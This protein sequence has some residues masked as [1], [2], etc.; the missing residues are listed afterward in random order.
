MSFV[1]QV[2]TGLPTKSRPA[3]SSTGLVYV[4][5]QVILAINWITISNRTVLIGYFS[6]QQLDVLSV[7]AQTFTKDLNQQ[8]DY[9]I[10][11]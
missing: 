8:H 10:E 1:F 3:A 9:D 5:Q 7:S 4:F 6:G 2:L 11:A